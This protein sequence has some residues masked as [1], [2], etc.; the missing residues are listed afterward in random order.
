MRRSVLARAAGGY[1]L[2]VVLSGLVSLLVIPAVIIAAG[3]EAWA[4]I[5][6]AQAVAGF[7][8]VPAVYGWGVVGPTEVASRAVEERGGYFADSLLSRAWLC[9]VIVPVAVVV[10]IAFAPDQ[11]VLAALTTVSGILVALGAGWFYV[12]ER[13]PLR[14]LLIDTAPR[15]AGTIAG[16]VAVVVTGNAVWFAGLQLAGVVV[17]AAI[18]SADILRRHRGWHASLSPVRAASNLRGQGHTVAMSATSA[19]YVNVP[20]L[21]VQVFVPSATA[22]YALAERMVRLALYATRPIVQ[23]AQGWVPNPD[24]D[25]LVSRAR[26]V[27]AIGLGLGALGGVAFAALAPWAGGILSGGELAIPFDLSIP[28]GVNLA[29]ILASQLTGFACLTALGMSRVLSTSTIAGA[30]VGTALM[31][32]LL[33]TIGVPGV[34]WGLAAAELAVLGVQLWKLAPRLARGV[35]VGS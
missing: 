11:P 12:G 8:F 5:A 30:V 14:F 18:A 29:A 31:I 22:V 9:V 3:T 26:R 1:G 10:A 19:V 25:V 27:T 6:V 4:T 23:V 34:A 20:I 21:L 7:A 13:S 24:P 33:L 17:S 15:L 35:A 2:S 28:M 16:A 32:P